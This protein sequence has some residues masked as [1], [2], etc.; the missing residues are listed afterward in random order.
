MWGHGSLGGYPIPNTAGMNNTAIKLLSPDTPHS[1]AS[2]PNHWGT[3]LNHIHAIV[4]QWQARTCF[5]EELSKQA[6]AWVCFSFPEVG[7]SESI[8]WALSLCRGH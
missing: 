2:I 1:G 8:L 4:A 6:R 5:S 3:H 7:H